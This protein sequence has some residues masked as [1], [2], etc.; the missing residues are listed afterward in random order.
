MRQVGDEV[1]TRELHTIVVE[2]GNLW[3]CVFSAWLTAVDGNG[4]PFQRFNG[5]SGWRGVEQALGPNFGP[6]VSATIVAHDSDVSL[7]F[8]ADSGGGRYRIWH[9]VMG[10]HGQ[11]Q[12]PKVPMELWPWQVAAGVCPKYGARGWDAS[13]TEIVLAL[14]NGP[15]PDQVFV[16]RVGSDGGYSMM[17]PIQRIGPTTD[18]SVHVSNVRV[19]AR[20]F[21]DDGMAFP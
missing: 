12:P 4:A 15:D 11:W 20:P 14:W 10:S 2:G 8:T 18:G 16:M 3:H 5:H 13:T 17:R 21:R 6:V 9:T 19:V 7:F 1:V